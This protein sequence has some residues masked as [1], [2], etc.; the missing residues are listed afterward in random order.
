MANRLAIA[1]SIVSLEL[2]FRTMNQQSP[3]NMPDGT[4]WRKEE[5]TLDSLEQLTQS[6]LTSQLPLPSQKI[7]K[8]INPEEQPMQGLR[9]RQESTV[10]G[11]KFIKLID[12]TSSSLEWRRAEDWER[13]REST[14]N[15]WQDYQEDQWGWRFNGS[16]SRSQWSFK[17]LVR[18]KFTSLEI[19]SFSLTHLHNQGDLSTL[20]NR[21]IHTQ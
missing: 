21:P 4:L 20:R 13:K 3:L 6:L 7:S 9:P 14:S 17:Q 19:D 12:A 2:R 5:Q 10:N 11:S 15:F 18:I 16:I 8:I 1:F